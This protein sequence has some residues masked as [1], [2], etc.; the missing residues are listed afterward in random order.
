MSQKLHILSHLQILA[1]LPQFLPAFAFA[2]HGK[3][4]IPTSESVNDVVRSLHNP[5]HSVLFPHNPEIYAHVRK[6][7]FEFRAWSSPIKAADINSV[8]DD[9]RSFIPYIT[10][11]TRNIT[12]GLIGRD[13]KISCAV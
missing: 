1:K 3:H 4:Y 13:H 2:D 7:A 8:P 10:T 6:L 9:S 11:L 12:I 5:V